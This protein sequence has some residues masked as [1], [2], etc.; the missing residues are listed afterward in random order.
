MPLK[1]PNIG[2]L[3]VAVSALKAAKV[4]SPESADVAYERIR[5][6]SEEIALRCGF[7]INQDRRP[8]LVLSFHKDLSSEHPIR[9]LLP[10]ANL[11]RLNQKHGRLLMLLFENRTRAV[12]H[13]ELL[14]AGWEGGKGSLASLGQRIKEIRDRI[15]P[16]MEIETIKG[17]GFQLKIK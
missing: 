1:H 12:L 16:H 5:S 14:A 10:E 2:E 15:E 9:K 7:E 11:K 8:P 17:Q 13:D 3:M 4:L 6:L